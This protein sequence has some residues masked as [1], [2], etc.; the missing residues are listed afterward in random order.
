MLRV[1]RALKVM[2]SQSLAS[3]KLPIQ[4]CL[5]QGPPATIGLCSGN[6]KQADRSRYAEQLF[7]ISMPILQERL[8]NCVE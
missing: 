6:A 8:E 3:Q 5:E 4:L 2:R 7:S 1:N